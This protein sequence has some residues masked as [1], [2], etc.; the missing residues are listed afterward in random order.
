[1]RLINV[2]FVRNCLRYFIK[3]DTPLSVQATKVVNTN[4]GMT[5]V[6]S[7]AQ[8]ENKKMIENVTSLLIY[9]D[10]VVIILFKVTFVI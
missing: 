7:V 10:Y 9:F 1:M 4:K 6:E 5:I 3:T 2:W 8:N